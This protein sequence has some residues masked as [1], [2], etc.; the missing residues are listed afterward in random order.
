MEIDIQTESNRLETLRVERPL[1]DELELKYFELKSKVAPEDETSDE[2]AELANT[3][4]C[5]FASSEQDG[6]GGQSLDSLPSNDEAADCWSAAE[7]VWTQG[8]AA[9]S[10]RRAASAFPA[11]AARRWHKFEFTDSRM[12]RSCWA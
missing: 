9:I 7:E 3:R 5:N 12:W 8:R 6:A 2:E 4:R 1:K 10:R 11:T